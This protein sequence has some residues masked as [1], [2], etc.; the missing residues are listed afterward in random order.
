ME[1]NNLLF[2]LTRWMHATISYL[3]PLTS[4]PPLSSDVEA[5]EGHGNDRVLT[6]NPESSYEEEIIEDDSELLDEQSVDVPRKRKVYFYLL[7]FSCVI[8]YLVLVLVITC[9]YPLK[10]DY[11]IEFSLPGFE[12]ESANITE[13]MKQS[14]NLYLK[15]QNRNRL[16]SALYDDLNITMFY[17]P[18]SNTSTYFASTIVPGFYQDKLKPTEVNVQMLAR[19]IPGLLH[20]KEKFDRTKFRVNVESVVR[21]DCKSL[22]K[23]KHRFLIDADIGFSFESGEAYEL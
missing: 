16:A 15:L 4:N 12:K 19:G 3:S 8:L 21:F 1:L 11:Y 5:G 7:Y 23:H 2:G 17:L 18:S 22:C 14:V 13:E 10:P 20:M 9:K 6:N